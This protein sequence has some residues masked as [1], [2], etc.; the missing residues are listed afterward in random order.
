M[1]LKKLPYAFLLLV[2]ST[3]F[4]SAQSQPCETQRYI[5]AQDDTQPSNTVQAF[6]IGS[7]GALTAVSGSPFETGGEGSG[8]G[9]LAAT[10]AVVTNNGL[11]LYV[12]NEQSGTVAGFNIDRSTGVLTTITGSPWTMPGDNFAGTS[13]A[14]NADET[15]M[16]L[17]R[18]NGIAI[19]SIDPSTGELNKTFSDLVLGPIINGLLASPDKSIL[20]AVSTD[21]DNFSVYIIESDGSLTPANGSP[22]PATAATNGAFNST[23]TK[24]YLGR[25][26]NGVSVY[27][28]GQAGQL[29][30]E[31]DRPVSLAP[32]SLLVAPGDRAMYGASPDGVLWRFDLDVNG[33]ITGSQVEEVGLQ[34][35]TLA[36]PKSGSF[37]FVKS[38]F[39]GVRAYAINPANQVS[40]SLIDGAPF[41][42]AS[43]GMSLAISEATSCSDSFSIQIRPP[44]SG[45]VNLSLQASAQAVALISSC[46]VD[47]VS[48]IDYSSA[49]FAGA[50]PI[51]N[52]N[53]IRKEIYDVNGDGRNDTVLFFNIKTTNLSKFATQATLTVNG[54]SSGSFTASQS[55]RMVGK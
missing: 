5:Y 36:M 12:S 35:S 17:G 50:S 52:R 32:Q 54:S 46:A 40:L 1:I 4:V 27:S 24:F 55:V 19:M 28:V 2:L 20:I 37:L 44:S 3:V 26:A 18:G 43:Q 21:S 47:T 6:C 13:I 33:A 34:Y 53:S 14:V 15:F 49:R 7:T 11:R 22:Y 39:G 29:S 31:E 25:Y 41:G 8:G 10:R 9:Y 16:Y 23:G 45:T 51:T 38:F 30:L 48:A 42:V